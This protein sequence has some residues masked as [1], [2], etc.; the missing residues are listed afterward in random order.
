MNLHLSVAT[1]DAEGRQTAM[2]HSDAVPAVA[3][4]VYKAAATEPARRCLRLV[5]CRSCRRP[6]FGP[7]IGVAGLQARAFGLE[8]RHTDRPSHFPRK[9]VGRHAD[10]RTEIRVD[11]PPPFPEDSSPTTTPTHEA[12]ARSRTGTA[13]PRQKHGRRPAFRSHLSP[14]P[15]RSRTEILRPNA[16]R[17]TDF[18]SRKRIRRESRGKPIAPNSFATAK[19][20]QQ[21]RS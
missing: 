14:A 10:D 13:P 2:A 5:L 21:P 4:T 8:K 16:S 1:F 12:D 6:G 17:P 18:R 19:T 9:P 3:G 11:R 15:D 7:R 20:P